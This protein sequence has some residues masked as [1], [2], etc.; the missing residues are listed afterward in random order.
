M[1]APKGPESDEKSSDDECLPATFSDEQVS[2]YIEFQSTAAAERGK[3]FASL[4]TPW[5]KLEIFKGGFT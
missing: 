3:L 2:L 1:G 5:Q 4:L